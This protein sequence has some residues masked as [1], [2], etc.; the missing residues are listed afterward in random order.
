MKIIDGRTQVI[1]KV[2]YF[3]DLNVNYS[4]GMC[5]KLSEWLL[6]Q[7]KSYYGFERLG[8]LNNDAYQC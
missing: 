1:F 6:N 4:C 2:Q 3:H 7:F 5:K 8:I